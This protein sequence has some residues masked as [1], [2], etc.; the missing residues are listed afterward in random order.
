[1]ANSS[2]G[3]LTRHSMFLYK[4]DYTELQDLF[5]DVGAAVIIR[6]LVHAYIAKN[7]AEGKPAPKL[8][9]V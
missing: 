2:S 5:P 9:N 4:G 1:M 8:E 7:K 6:N 3:N